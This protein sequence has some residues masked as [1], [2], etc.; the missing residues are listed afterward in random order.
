MNETTD[1]AESKG[2]QESHATPLPGG[3]LDA[4]TEQQVAHP[5]VSDD[6]NRR[7]ADELDWGLI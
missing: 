1:F 4:S 5:F 3:A 6:G 7:L 2:D